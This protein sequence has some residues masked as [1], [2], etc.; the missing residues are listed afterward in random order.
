MEYQYD[1]NIIVIVINVYLFNF[2]AVPPSK[3]RPKTFFPDKI[4]SIH[5]DNCLNISKL[6]KVLRKNIVAVSFFQNFAIHP[7]T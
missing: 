7:Y 2:I 3:T 4:N 5:N 6:E 1:I